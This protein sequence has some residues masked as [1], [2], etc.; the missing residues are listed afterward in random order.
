M[1]LFHITG[2]KNHKVSFDA[3][4]DSIKRSIDSLKDEYDNTWN[5]L[6]ETRKKWASIQE[7]IIVIVKSHRIKFSK[8]LD[9]CSNEEMIQEIKRIIEKLPE[10][11]EILEKYIK[12]LNKYYSIMTDYSNKLMK[13]SEKLNLMSPLEEDKDEEL[14]IDLDAYREAKNRSMLGLEEVIATYTATDKIIN[15]K[16]Q[17]LNTSTVEKVPFI[18]INNFLVTDPKIAYAKETDE[19]DYLEYEIKGNLTLID[20]AES[21]YGNKSY[22]VFLYNYSTNK[23]IID[24]IAEKY[25]VEPSVIAIIKGFLDGVKLK[26]PL[27]LFDTYRVS[28]NVRKVA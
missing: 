9:K 27:D 6:N 18:E 17:I 15:S 23:D 19:L 2:L 26:F 13:L 8:S 24:E 7:S 3:T 12:D 20:I 4:Y 16:N 5:A 11:Q 28:E 1:D 21:V 25:E 14:I 10:E 22:W